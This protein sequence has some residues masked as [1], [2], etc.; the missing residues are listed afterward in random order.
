MIENS[1][2][3]GL[4]KVWPEQSKVSKIF[5]LNGLLLT[6]IY[7]FWAKN[8]QRS[9]IAWHWRMMQNLKKNWLASSKLT[10]GF[11]RMLAWALENP[12]HLH[13]NVLLLTKV[14]NVRGKKYRGVIFDGSEDWCKNWTKT[15]LHFQKWY[16][17]FGKFSQSEK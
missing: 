7:N 13:F 10:W 8:L 1:R 4:N 12:K 3:N 9:Y 11:W 6:K 15:D 2:R 17:E 14:Y 5:H 16:E